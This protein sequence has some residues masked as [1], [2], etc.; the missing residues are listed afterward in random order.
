MLTSIRRESLSPAGA[1]AVASR[2]RLPGS[3]LTYRRPTG[4]DA[5]RAV[6]LSPPQGGRPEPSWAIH[7]DHDV[8]VRGSERTRLPC[9]A[10]G[11]DVSGC[12]DA[13]IWWSPGP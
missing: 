3:S 2:S 1:R 5:A 9:F 4:G 12:S 6:R 10:R 13:A 11:T 7:R 8:S